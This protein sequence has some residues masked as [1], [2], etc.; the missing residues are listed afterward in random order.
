LSKVYNLIAFAALVSAPGAFI[1]ADAARMAAQT[2]QTAKPDPQTQLLN[3]YRKYPDRYI[4]ISGESWQY[5]RNTRI[6]VHSFTMK[7]IAGVAYSEI[8]VEMT[9]L[10]AEGKK[11]QV[12]SVKIPGIL[13]A[14]QIKK[15]KDMK[16]KKVPVQCDQV[17]LKVTTAKIHP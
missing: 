13:A 17:L 15:I 12:Q 16:V 1:T 10:S 4:R 14:Y 7:N 8:E 6:A 11:L 3:N 9:Y 2:R 5:D